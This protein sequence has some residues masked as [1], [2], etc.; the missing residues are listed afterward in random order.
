MRCL[1]DP[2]LFLPLLAEATDSKTLHAQIFQHCIFP[3]ALLSLAD[4]SF[5]A[6][7][8][9]LMHSLGTTNFASMWFLND[10]GP[11]LASHPI[12]L[13]PS[14]DPSSLFRTVCF[15]R[16]DRPARRLLHRERGPQL[17]CVPR[18][19]ARSRA[20]ERHTNGTRQTLSRSP[21]HARLPRGYVKLAHGRGEV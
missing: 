9:R 1:A 17:R 10:V 21:L 7:F 14:A 12:L 5:S 13:S 18:L 19:A 20:S 2:V 4:A 8:L 3:R 15:H 11:S 16:V 6:R